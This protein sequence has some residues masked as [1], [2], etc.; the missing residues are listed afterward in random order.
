LIHPRAPHFGR[1]TWNASGASSGRK[2][3]PRRRP[4]SRDPP[5]LRS[6]YNIQLFPPPGGAR[7]RAAFATLT[8]FG[9]SMNA[10][11][12]ALL[13]GFPRSFAVSFS[14]N[15]GTLDPLSFARFFLLLETS[16]ASPYA[17]GQ[18]FPANHALPTHSSFQL[19]TDESPFLAFPFPYSSVHRPSFPLHP[20]GVAI[21]F[22]ITL[23]FP[24]HVTAP[25]PLAPNESTG[26]H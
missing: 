13:P 2:T 9:G 7:S 26:D 4:V 25:S 17:R 24:A 10:F 21:I 20:G 1:R 16:L 6:R 5:F 8:H 22:K 19:V 14:S 23:F 11:P 12:V 18:R 15:G 3:R